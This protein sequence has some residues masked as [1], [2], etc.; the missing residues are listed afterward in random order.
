MNLISQIP[1]DVLPADAKGAVIANMHN[2]LNLLVLDNLENLLGV[3]E[4]VPG[5]SIGKDALATFS[6]GIKAVANNDARQ[7]NNQFQSVI[8]KIDHANPHKQNALLH[9]TEA[10]KKMM[11]K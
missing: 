8:Q 5:V 6:S 2:Q 1:D 11:N 3:L 4:S 7:Q 10:I 9:R